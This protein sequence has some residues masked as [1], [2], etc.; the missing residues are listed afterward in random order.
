MEGLPDVMRATLVAWAQRERIVRRAYVFGSRA[1]GTAT[2]TSDLDLALILDEPHG[3]ALSELIV[4]RS[5]WKTEL[6]RALGVPVKDI[7]L[8]DDP[9]DIAYRAVREH[10][11]LVYER[12]GAQ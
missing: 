12:A 8:A 10:G 6:T 7:H 2:P 11:V 4:R 9:E 5:S 3:N 1:K